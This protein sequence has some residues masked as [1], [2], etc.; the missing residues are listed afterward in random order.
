[1]KTTKSN[2]FLKKKKGGGGQE[3]AYIQ[4]TTQA[5]YKNMST[6]N[7]GHSQ[8]SPEHRIFFNN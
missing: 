3:T 4:V 5:N 1:M 2:D 8:N 6:L 7:I